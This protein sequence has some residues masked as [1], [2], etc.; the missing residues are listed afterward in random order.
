MESN[1]HWLLVDEPEAAAIYVE[2]IEQFI[3]IGRNAQP[4]GSTR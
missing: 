1:N 2:A 3:G 4:D